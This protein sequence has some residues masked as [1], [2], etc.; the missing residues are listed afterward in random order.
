MDVILLERVENLGQMGDVVK[1][2]PG[3]ARNFLLPQQKAMRA[4]KDNIAYFETQKSQLE[5]QN[6]Q[7]RQEAEQVSEKMDDMSVVLIRSAGDTGQLYGSVS[8]RDIADALTEAGATVD[9]RQVELER[10]IKTLGLHTVRVRLHPEVAVNVT[11]NVARSDDE[12]EAQARGEDVLA[13]DDGFE[14]DEDLGD[15]APDLEDLLEDEALPAAE[16]DLAADD[17]GE[18]AEE[19]PS[20]A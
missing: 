17:A 8:N 2:K 9:R 6:L 19:K 3:Y 12:A 1:V 14:F 18:A 10:P 16:E 15:D 20:G 7:K 4:S 11:A 5:A 13:R